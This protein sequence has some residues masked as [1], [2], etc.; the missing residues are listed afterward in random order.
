MTDPSRTNQELLEENSL[1]K[2]KIKELEHSETERKRVAEA[3]RKS[4]ENYRQLFD[5]SP[6]AIYQIDFRTGKLLKGNDII[7]EFLGCR[8]EDI[9][10]IT[11]Y[12]F[13]TDASKQLFS[14]R[15][16]KMGLGEKVAENPEYE[17]VDKNGK[18]RWLQLNSHNIYN[19]EGAVIGA[20]VVAHEIT[21]R[22]RAEKALRESES[23]LQAI[24][25][26]TADG[27]L[28]INKKN[29][30]L[31]TNERFA[32]MWKI[33]DE[34]MATKNDS[35][36]LQYILDQL[37]DPQDF[38]QKVQQLYLSDADNFDTL[39]FWDGRIFE[40]L[41]QPL[42]IGTEWSGRVWSF[43]DVTDRKQ[44]E[45]ENIRLV[46]RLQRAEKMEALGT[47]A[48]GVAHDLNNVL[49]IVVGYAELLLN[50]VD[51]SNPIRPRLLSIMSGGERAAAIVQ[52]LLTLARRGVASRQI[53]NLN[54]M[55]VDN[56]NSPEF[57]A[58]S[59][60]HPRVQIKIDLEPN[61]LNISGSPVHIGK[62]LFNLVSN[63]CEAMPNGGV[64]TIRTVN[65]YIDKP[66]Q[67]YDDI[68]EGDYVVLSVSDTGEG[69]PAAD[70]KR[71]F[72]PFYT[73]KVMGRSG[74][75][76]GLAVV[77]GTV[78]DHQGYVNVQSEVGKGSTFTLYFPVTREEITTERSA[79]NI[80]EYMGKG[81]A[82]LV[83][84]DVQGQRDLAA[85]ML[86][87]LN[88][89]VEGVSSGEAAIARVKEHP[90][91]LLVLDMIMDPGM[92]GLETY[93]RVLAVCPK[94]KAI[95]VSGFSETERVSQA[96]ALGA[97][98]YVRKPYILERLGL[99]V[100]KELD[101][102]TSVLEH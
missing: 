35:D 69:I 75:G 48:G 4:E 88:Y 12:D 9:P 47:L 91:D 73:K 40:R 1:L 86:R 74:T 20:N 27:I 59:S 19:A 77:W 32:E 50:E 72:E 5:N 8:Q 21:E 67:G 36:L 80:S 7:C 82:I 62:T 87:N 16:T 42:M 25:R 93:R 23:S 70:L 81:E 3:L 39:Y 90:V 44:A 24:L 64:L 45:E 61:S 58:L 6:T 22:K 94:Q 33:P 96:Q 66:I 76:L 78:K 55:I 46:E 41:S 11:P 30:I 52:D 49:G 89:R 79:V 2:Q 18:R 28:A 38:L 29:D 100:R 84:D 43:R 98:A 10:S 57:K 53:L 51:K 95:I 34:V 26:S 101:R 37:V 13:M 65:Q 15:L 83:V 60:Y 71:I 102:S 68:Q 63:A 54:K 31:F 17:I 85:E 97:G 56:Q 92:D 14:E 99:A